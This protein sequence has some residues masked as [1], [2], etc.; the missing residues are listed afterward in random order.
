MQEEG[1]RGR[2]KAF[3]LQPKQRKQRRHQCRFEACDVL[4]SNEIGVS[5]KI[6]PEKAPRTYTCA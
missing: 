6:L 3:Q 2:D 4:G 1:G 5:G